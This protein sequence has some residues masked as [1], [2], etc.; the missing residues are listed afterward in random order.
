M[1]AITATD[2][3]GSQ[4]PEPKD[5]PSV[6]VLSLE[7]KLL[8]MI[9]WGAADL[10]LQKHLA[11]WTGHGTAAYLQMLVDAP[12]HGGHSNVTTRRIR[13]KARVIIAP[14]F[15]VEHKPIP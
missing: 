7:G 6:K 1:S 3:A 15:H 8:P 12:F 4:A 11:Y 2:W 9:P 10:L 13:N 14:D 5:C